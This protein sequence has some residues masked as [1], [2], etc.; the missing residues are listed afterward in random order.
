MTQNYHHREHGGSLWDMS[1]CRGIFT[2]KYV[3][4]TNM[5]KELLML[6]IICIAVCTHTLIQENAELCALATLVPVAEAMLHC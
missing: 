5:N 4:L 1:C 6:V 3:F 2:N